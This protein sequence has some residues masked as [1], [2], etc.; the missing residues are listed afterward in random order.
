MIPVILFP[1]SLAVIDQLCDRFTNFPIVN[2]H[3]QDSIL[4][5]K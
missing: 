1:A 3:I 5:L 4:S 2:N